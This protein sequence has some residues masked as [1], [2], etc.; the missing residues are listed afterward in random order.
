MTDWLRPLTETADWIIS[1]DGTL[2]E[3]SDRRHTIELVCRNTTATQAVLDALE[4]WQTDYCDDPDAE[5]DIPGA[6]IHGIQ[7][8][9][10]HLVEARAAK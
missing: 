6:N 9:R 4:A 1:I 10:T 3:R 7:V 2:G 8:R 5:G